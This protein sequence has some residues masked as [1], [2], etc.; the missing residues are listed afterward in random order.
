MTQ[1]DHDQP[2]ND[3]DVSGTP[4]DSSE[5][6]YRQLG[7]EGNPFARPEAKAPANPLALA[8]DGA[9]PD[10]RALDPNEDDQLHD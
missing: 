4:D 7:D 8:E 3:R 2:E 9:A 6:D 5:P 1:S 10:E